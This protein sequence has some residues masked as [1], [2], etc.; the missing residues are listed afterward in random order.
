MKGP[1]AN[2]LKQAQQM[3]QK[4]ED[5][6]AELVSLQV[7]GEAGGG[8]VKINMTGRNDVV[9][10]VIDDLLLSEDKAMLEDLIAAAMNDAVRKV[11]AARDEKMSAMTSGLNLPLDMKLPF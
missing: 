8:M 9:S 1:L 3:Q 6:K 4:M 10:V 11:E 2:M 5:A 7:R